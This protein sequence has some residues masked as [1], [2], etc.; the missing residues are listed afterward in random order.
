[1]PDLPHN[2]RAPRRP[3]AYLLP[4]LFDR[5]KDDAP[6]RK[7]EAP[8]EYTVNRNQLRKII[9]RDLTYLLNSVSL[10]DEIDR[11]LYPEASSSVVNYGMPPIAGNYLHEQKWDDIE[12]TIRQAILNFEPRLEPKTLVVAP[13]LKGD[14][15]KQYNVL[16]FEIRGQVLTDPY[17]M[18]F[19]VQSAFDLETNQM[20]VTLR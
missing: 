2:E 10:D 16:L 1:M 11:S 8:G 19:I 17:P 20:N 5:L 7:S 14:A 18:E 3:N 12:K 4:T 13:L 9:Q 6:Q 15:A